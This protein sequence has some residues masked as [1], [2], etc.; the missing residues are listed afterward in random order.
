M[1]AVFQD[2]LEASFDVNA[3]FAITGLTNVSLHPHFSCE[4]GDVCRL[5]CFGHYLGVPIRSR[6]CCTKSA[7]PIWTH[8]VHTQ[9][10]KNNA[11]QRSYNMVAR[12]LINAFC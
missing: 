5:C 12:K 7:A 8:V 1:G 10:Q 3:L 6:V 11:R 9:T 2:L 4:V